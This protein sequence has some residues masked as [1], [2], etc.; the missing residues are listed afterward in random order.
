MINRDR[1]LLFKQTIRAAVDDQLIVAYQDFGIAAW[2][3]TIGLFARA[4]DLLR[5]SETGGV[6]IGDDHSMAAD[7]RLDTPE[8]QVIRPAASRAR[9]NQSADYQTNFFTHIAFL[10]LHRAHAGSE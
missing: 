3:E 10:Q 6:T 4:S 8:Q 1:V 9:H 7:C 2:H 5:R